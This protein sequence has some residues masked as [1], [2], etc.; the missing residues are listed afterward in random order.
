MRPP[1]LSR[2]GLALLEGASR[3]RFLLAGA[4]LSAGAV[5]GCG[6]DEPMGN[7]VAT[8]D[9][10]FRGGE[11]LLDVP[12]VNEGTVPLETLVNQGW[13]GRL[14][15]DL[16]KLNPDALVI[17]NERFYVRT[18]YP[19]LLDPSA[20]WTVDV[21][22][23]ATPR[24]LSL[25]DLSPLVKDQGVHLL[26]CS[27]NGKGGHFG[28]L[29]AAQWA[30]APLSDVLSLLDVAPSATRV[31]ISG[32]DQHS[33]PS[34]GGHSTPGASWIFS[35]DQLAQTGAFLATEMNGVPLP[36]DHGAPLRLFVPGW[37]GCTCIKWV[38][39]IV[40]VDEGQ[41]ATAQMQ[42]FASRTH[43]DGVPALARDY[44]PAALQVAAM[45]VRIEKW[46]LQGQ[47][48]YRVVGILWGGDAPTNALQIRFDKNDPWQPVEVCPPRTGTNTW[49]L[50]SHRWQPAAPGT[51]AIEH[52]IADPGVPQQRL[53]SGWYV[54]EVT[55][56]EV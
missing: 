5:L 56:D 42:E 34:A 21:S 37:Y 1:P 25:D 30:G 4:S 2:A 29:S 48:A 55:I 52:R 31:L 19:D 47:I 9:D 46:R 8:C 17:E 23:L 14:Y 7:G 22:G 43:Q 6:S 51:Y 50:W 32:F 53:D 38:N 3:R 54:R 20:P 35:F 18:R 15:T 36:P 41:P 39:E 13:D 26:E 11:R 49:T 45:P 10:P 44:R 33:V 16:T 24:Q 40:L 27:G 28:L 12:F